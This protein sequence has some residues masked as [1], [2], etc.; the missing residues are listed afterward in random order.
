ML[1]I[2]SGCGWGLNQI[3]EKFP[4]ELAIGTDLNSNQLD[5]AMRHDVDQIVQHDLTTNLPFPDGIFSTAVCYIVLEQIDRSMISH[6]L[7]EVLRTM[8]NSGKFVLATFN[9]DMFSPNN[10]KWFEHNKHEYTTDEIK[11]D[12]T[13]AG[14]NAIKSYGQR[15]VEPHFYSIYSYI[16][17]FIEDQKKKKDP[18]YSYP[19]ASRNRNIYPPYFSTTHVEPVEDHSF[20]KP[21]IDLILCDK[22]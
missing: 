18:S 8:K 6:V 17:Q 12:L 5:E 1:E 13:S 3:H 9:R 19:Y 11:S 7:S 14:F 20:T 15:F 21:V 22:A 10:R 16:T 2:G 4:G